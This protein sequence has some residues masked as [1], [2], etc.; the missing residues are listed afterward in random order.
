MKL[1]AISLIVFFAVKLIYGY[2]GEYGC[3]TQSS[4]VWVS[5][6][7]MLASFC[8]ALAVSSIRKTQRYLFWVG[9]IVFVVLM[10]VNL[11]CV[12]NNDLFYTLITRS[13]KISFGCA[14]VI[15]GAIAMNYII[16]KSHDRK[17]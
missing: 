8:R 16:I 1:A 14:A 3:I 2:W 10:V 9:A 15:I 4:L 13:E 7:F 11:A 6:Y 12:I 17:R 5:F